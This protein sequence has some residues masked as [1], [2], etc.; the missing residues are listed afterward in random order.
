MVD[1]LS[2]VL[3]TALNVFV[4][5]VSCGFSMRVGFVKGLVWRKTLMTNTFGWT[6]PQQTGSLSRMILGELRQ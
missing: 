5:I 4:L 2:V 3:V 1:S 6:S